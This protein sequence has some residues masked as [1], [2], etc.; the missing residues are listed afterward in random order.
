MLLWFGSGAAGVALT[1]PI[2]AWKA[3]ATGPEGDTLWMSASVNE[4]SSLRQRRGG[5]RVGRVRRVCTTRAAAWTPARAR[6]RTRAAHAPEVLQ[7][8]IEVVEGT[9]HG[10]RLA[11]ARVVCDECDRARARSRRGA[12]AAH[13]ARVRH[14][15]GP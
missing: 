3:A 1:M 4:P 10:G 8:T 12:A 11:R 5:G 7:L 6:A 14:P 2:S 13:T 9:V 15:R